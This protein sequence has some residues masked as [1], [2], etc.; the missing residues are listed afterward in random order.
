M[1][2]PKLQ[3]IAN[4]N[5]PMRQPLILDNTRHANSLQPREATRAL[6][7]H[8]INSSIYWIVPFLALMFGGFAI[9]QKPSLATLLWPSI[10]LG[11]LL[12]LTAAKA[13]TGSPIRNISGLMMI[14]A[15]TTGVA[16]FLS[17]NGFTLIAVELAILISVLAILAGWIF[18]SAPLALLSTFSGLI[19]LGSSFPEL[20]LTTGLTDQTS[21]LG[22]G[23]IPFL[24]LGQIMLAHKV[25]SSIVVLAAVIAGYVWLCTLTKDMPLSALAGL[26]FAVAAAHYW[27][28][29]VWGETM[30]FGAGIHRTCAWV[31]AMGAAIYVQS[32][33]LNTNAG[34]AKPFWP[35]NTFWWTVLGAAMFTL[36]IA[37]LMRYKSSRISLPGIFI[38]CFAVGTLPLATA[39]PDL[40]HVGFDTIPGLNARPG[41][42]LVIGAAILASGL[43][44]LVSG[45]KSG[46]LLDMTIG[47]LAI[48]IESVVLFQPAR[49]DT[50]LSI[51]FIVS[52]ICALCL[53]GLIAGASRDEKRTLPEYA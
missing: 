21:Q 26:G 25:R 51:V 39:K 52:L 18:K 24:L 35:P 53:G 14:V 30:G 20:G 7:T 32:I 17:Q 12:F 38:V 11:T 2:Q 34:Q 3:V 40:I 31:V 19:Y 13:E 4:D 10:G 44:W 48:G 42:G 22:T 15:V 49:F 33:W 50:D 47:A 6:K 16:A 28:G 27:V 43:I 9:A 36:F 41:L 8:Q 29:K 23:L 45:L 5:A 1:R 46:R 37:S